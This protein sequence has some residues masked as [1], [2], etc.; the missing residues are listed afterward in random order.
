MQNDTHMDQLSHSSQYQLA[1]RLV[2]NV[3][4][5]GAIRYCYAEQW[6]GVLDQVHRVAA[7]EGGRA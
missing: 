1:K 4:V 5:A 3:G 6:I 7:A 2:D